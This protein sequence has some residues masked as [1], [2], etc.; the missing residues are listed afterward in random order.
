MGLR[1]GVFNWF[2]DPPPIV[3]MDIAVDPIDSGDIPIADIPPMP[4]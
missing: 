3:P 1:L 4:T 2:I